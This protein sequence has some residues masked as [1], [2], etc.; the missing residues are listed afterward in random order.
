LRGSA[1]IRPDFADLP[2]PPGIPGGGENYA[3]RR[4]SSLDSLERWL[5][6]PHAARIAA[7]LGAITIAPSSTLVKLSRASPST[8]AI[9]RCVY[10][11]PILFVLTVVEDRRYGSRS[12]RER[13][14]AAASGVLLGA[15]LILWHRA[16]GDVGAGLATVL[17]NV[18]VVVLP[19][20][21]WTLLSERPVPRLLAALPVTAVGVVLISGAL[22]HGAYGRDPHAGA[23]YGVTGGIAYAGALLLLR[24]AARDRR[25]LAGPLFDVT[26]SA[27]IFCSVTG[28]VVGDARF[29][30]TWPGT[31]WLVLLALGP[32]VI[33]WMLIGFSLPRLPAALTSLLLMIQ[34]IGSMI[35]GAIVFSEDPSPLQLIGVLVVIVAVVFATRTPSRAVHVPAD[36]SEPLVGEA[37]PATRV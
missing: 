7:V 34:P 8:A 18:Q 25:R 11:L 23:V 13:T 17:A 22:E 26:L 20:L 36:M 31:G 2:V 33:G 12:W 30:P 27:A 14:V 19:L 29:I 24:S 15:D 35:L 37:D 10:A 3:C 9:F 16:I 1:G 6:H 32:Q 4:T 5:K 28:L 21:A